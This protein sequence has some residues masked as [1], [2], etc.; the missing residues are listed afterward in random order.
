MCFIVLTILMELFFYKKKEFNNDVGIDQQN[1]KWYEIKYQIIFY[2]IYDYY[3]N[4]NNVNDL[5]ISVT[6]NFGGYDYNEVLDNQNK[7]NHEIKNE[8]KFDD[9]GYNEIS[10]HFQKEIK[11]NQYN[12]WNDDNG[13]SFI[14]IVM[15]IQILF[16]VIFMNFVNK[17]KKKIINF[18]IIMIINQRSITITIIIKFMIFFLIIHSKSNYFIFK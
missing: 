12:Q 11:M 18:I 17:K 8:W 5:K 2:I 14:R 1:K 4:R 13:K 7:H 9:D 6:Q 16:K 15:N 3:C 10:F